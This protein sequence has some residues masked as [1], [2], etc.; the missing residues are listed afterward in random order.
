MAWAGTVT[1]I[2][3][4][5]VQPAE[6]LERIGIKHECVILSAGMCLFPDLDIMTPCL[7]ACRLQDLH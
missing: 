4:G 7:L 1:L 2:V 6:G 3:G 5:T